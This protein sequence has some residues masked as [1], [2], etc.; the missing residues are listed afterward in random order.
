[1]ESI[2][3]YFLWVWVI[4]AHSLSGHLKPQFVSSSNHELA[5]CLDSNI[6]AIGWQR[7]KWSFIFPQIS[8]ILIHWNNIMDPSLS[9]S[10]PFIQMIDH[11]PFSLVLDLLL[12]KQSPSSSFSTT[13]QALV[14]SLLYFFTT[15]ILSLL[16][17]IILN[18]W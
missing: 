9:F 13:F 15:S 8:P 5:L 3:E 4:I 10:R 14:I 1:M 12:S 11:V 16:S 18:K 6:V 17:I 2:I 7:G